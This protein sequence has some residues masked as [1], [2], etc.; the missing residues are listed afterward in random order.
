M[1][2]RKFPLN[3]LKGLNIT[4][5]KAKDNGMMNTRDKTTPPKSSK[6]SHK[7]LHFDTPHHKNLPT[8]KL[9]GHHL[10]YTPF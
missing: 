4:I 5:S 2:P 6:S 3:F 7:I 1:T 9:Y 10:H 8:K